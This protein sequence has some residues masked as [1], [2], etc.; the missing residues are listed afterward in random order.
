[1]YDSRKE[2]SASKGWYHTFSFGSRAGKSVLKQSRLMVTA[3]WHSFLK[4]Y[5]SDEWSRAW[6]VLQESSIS[7]CSTMIWPVLYCSIHRT[8]SCSMPRWKPCRQ[9]SRMIS[10]NQSQK[11]APHTMVL[12]AQIDWMEMMQFVPVFFFCWAFARHFVT[13]DLWYFLWCVGE[14]SNVSART[15]LIAAHVSLLY[16]SYMWPP[17][18]L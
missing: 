16:V 18:I 3:R 7:F 2:C 5:Q 14:L 17:H 6:V 15:I 9:P 12:F 4:L 1:M 11:E 8:S 10:V 13:Q